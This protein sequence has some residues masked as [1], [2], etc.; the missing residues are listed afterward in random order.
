MP[1]LSVDV[2]DFLHLK[3]PIEVVGPFVVQR[4]GDS[5]RSRVLRDG[6]LAHGSKADRQHGIRDYY[7]AQGGIGVTLTLKELVSAGLGS[8]N[9]VREALGVLVAD[10]ILDYQA[11]GGR[12]ESTWKMIRT[13]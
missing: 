13:L 6:G 1:Q 11:G 10:G 9:T 12:V 8:E 7:A 3:Q 4:D 2:V 5:G